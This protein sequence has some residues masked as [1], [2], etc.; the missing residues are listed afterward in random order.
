MRRGDIYLVELEPVRGTEAN[1]T[2]PALI[3]SNNA[4]NRSA[5]RH[6][7]GVVTVVPLTSNVSRVFPFQVL[8][9][10][11]DCGIAVDSKAQA[12]QVR[13]IDVE[14]LRHHIGSVPDKTMQSVDQALRSHL[15]L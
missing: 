2:R 4:A 3:V 6:G 8:I 14:R 13:S 10:A 12:E 15:A 9:S 1:K 5:E 7:R 11:K